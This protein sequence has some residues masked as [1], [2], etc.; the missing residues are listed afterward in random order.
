MPTQKTDIG[1]SSR[2]LVLWLIMFCL[3]GSS[4]TTGADP[5]PDDCPSSMT[6]YWRLEGTGDPY[7]DFK[8]GA[9]G[10]CGT[11]CPSEVPGKIESGQAF[12][13][14]AV[15]GIDIAGDGFNW[16]KDDN[17]TIEFWMQKSEVCMEDGG[18]ND[19]E[20]IVG[21]NS[22]TSNLQWWVGV[23]C[24]E[25]PRGRLTFYLRDTGGAAHS[26]TSTKI[27]TNSQWHHIA[28]VKAGAEIRLYVDGSLEGSFGTAYSSEFGD[29]T[30]P[31][32]LGYMA[33]AFH[34]TG[35]LDEVAIYEAALTSDEIR[36]HYYLVRH[37]CAYCLDPVAVMPLGDSITFGSSS[38]A[39][40]PPD[41]DCT[42]IPSSKYEVSYRKKLWDLL[43]SGLYKVDFVGGLKGGELYEGIEGFDPDNEGHNG[44]R[45][46]QVADGAPNWLSTHRPEVILLHIGTN[47]ISADWSTANVT[48]TVN[49]AVSYT[50]LTLPTIYSV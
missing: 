50:H 8:G 7:A 4:A 37:Y 11:E 47:D 10:T 2:L 22:T 16:A 34:Y 19:N 15:T 35:K 5:I 6:G 9:A 1:G 17:F 40:C 45:A 46:D 20:V 14:T 23:N 36:S 33:G 48:A 38:G 28:A 42:G 43:K 29:P 31:V 24:S 39:E 30:A 41:E 13:R 49:D 27:L 25:E 26:V 21:R 3:I 12:D 44:M 18:V 32:T